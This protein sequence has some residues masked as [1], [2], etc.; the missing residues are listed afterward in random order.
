VPEYTRDLVSAYMTSMVTHTY[1]E[2]P[3]AILLDKFRPKTRD[4]TLA[5]PKTPVAAKR[6]IDLKVGAKMNEL[7]NNNMKSTSGSVTILI[8]LIG[9]CTS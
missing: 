5:T 3:T 1:M 6:W 9:R 4:V 8:A 7:R 2:K